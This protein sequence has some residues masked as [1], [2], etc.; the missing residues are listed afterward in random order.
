MKSSVLNVPM[1]WFDLDKSELQRAWTDMYDKLVLSFGA[2]AVDAA[3]EDGD[4]TAYGKAEMVVI[5]CEGE[6]ADKIDPL[7]DLYGV[8]TVISM[9]EAIAF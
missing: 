7:V 9:V 4:F 8:E 3:V 6:L 5:Q 2:E 1:M